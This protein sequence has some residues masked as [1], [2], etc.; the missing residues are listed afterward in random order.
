MGSGSPA[1]SASIEARYERFTVTYPSGT[2]F[3][4]C[5][6]IGG[7]ATLREVAVAHPMAVVTPDE[8]SRVTA[9]H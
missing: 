3:E 6:F 7:G 4:S 9:P 2:A 8:D 1:T 5:C